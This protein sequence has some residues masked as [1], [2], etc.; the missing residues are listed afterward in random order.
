M[1]GSKRLS[2]NLASHPLRNRRFFYSLFFSLGIV[3]IFTSFL[4]GKIFFKFRY[5]SQKTRDSIEKTNQL[6]KD[7]QRDEKK[8]STRIE[9]AIDKYETKVDLVNGIILRKS[10]SWIEFLSD[11][12]SSLP[13]SSYIVSL[14]PMLTENSKVLLKFKVVSSGVGD[15]L[16]LYT[17]LKD[18]KFRNIQIHSEAEIEGRLLLSEISLNYE[19][20][21]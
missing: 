18:L 3:L 17:N 19:R 5:E 9:D 20:D 13:D 16:K 1:I 7:A 11:L 14:A 4:A 10:F 2:L 15:L 12:E 6:I 8:F 21:I